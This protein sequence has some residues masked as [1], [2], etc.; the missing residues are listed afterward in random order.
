MGDRTSQADT[1]DR[2]RDFGFEP[3]VTHR[4][5]LWYQFPILSGGRKG[6]RRFL[7]GLLVTSSLLLTLVALAEACGSNGACFL[8]PL[9]L[10]VLLLVQVLGLAFLWWFMAAAPASFANPRH[11]DAGPGQLGAA[12]RTLPSQDAIFDPSYGRR[13]PPS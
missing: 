11:P 13:E 9:L 2:L 7:I 1:N 3:P 6:R 8:A 4:W 12:Q 10:L 5:A